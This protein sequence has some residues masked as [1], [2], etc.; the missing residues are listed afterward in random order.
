MSR[1]DGAPRNGLLFTGIVLSALV[2]EAGFFRLPEKVGSGGPDTSAA[3]CTCTNDWTA[4]LL[5]EKDICAWFAWKLSLPP[6]PAARCRIARP[7]GAGS[8]GSGYTITC[9]PPVVLTVER[10]ICAGEPTAV[11]S[12][13]SLPGWG[14]A[15]RVDVQHSGRVAVEGKWQV[16]LHPCKWLF[17]HGND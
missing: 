12:R 6:L 3:V 7:G 14:E 17:S 8:D 2:A 11:T 13:L 4:S 9:D 15:G 1:S 16:G 10:S 5:V